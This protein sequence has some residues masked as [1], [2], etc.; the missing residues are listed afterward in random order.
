MTPAQEPFSVRLKT[1]EVVSETDERTTYQVQLPSCTCPDFRWRDLPVNPKA[2][3]PGEMHLCKHIRYAM[4]Q[5]A[6]WRRRDA[7]TPAD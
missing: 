5:W 6:S 2:D 1:V 3:P 7:L 4:T